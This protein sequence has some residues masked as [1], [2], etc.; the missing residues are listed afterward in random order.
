VAE[1]KKLAQLIAIANDY[2]PKTG[3]GK[4][5]LLGKLCE[6][7]SGASSSSCLEHTVTCSVLKHANEAEQRIK[8]DLIC[9]TVVNCRF[10]N[11]VVLQHHPK[12]NGIASHRWVDLKL[13]TVAENKNNVKP[14]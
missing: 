8:R 11:V 6:L 2:V 12:K 10:A 9:L 1:S 14:I 4:Q 5:P 3:Q 13:V 7:A